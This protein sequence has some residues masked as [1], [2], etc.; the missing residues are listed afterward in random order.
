MNMGQAIKRM[1]EIRAI[2]DNGRCNNKAAAYTEVGS[3][4]EQAWQD[5][6]NELM[7]LEMLW[8]CIVDNLGHTAVANLI[9]RRNNHD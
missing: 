1:A 8:D 6:F 2:I 3:I 4:D 9:E 5:L 7:R